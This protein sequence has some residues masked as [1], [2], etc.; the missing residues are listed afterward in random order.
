MEEKDQTFNLLSLDLPL[1]PV[2]KD[3]SEKILIPQVQL[4]TLL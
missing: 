4:F 2:F 1:M 3:K